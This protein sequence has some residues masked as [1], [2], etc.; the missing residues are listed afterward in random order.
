MKG[1]NGFRKSGQEEKVASQRGRIK[2][3]QLAERTGG[4]TQSILENGDNLRR[5]RA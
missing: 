2:G 3:I 1:K 4:G 5:E